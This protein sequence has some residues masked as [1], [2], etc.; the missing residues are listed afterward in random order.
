M[1]SSLSSTFYIIYKEIINQKDIEKIFEENYF[2]SFQV[3]L[4]DQ[5]GGMKFAF[6]KPLLQFYDDTFQIFVGN[7]NYGKNNR[8][9]I[10]FTSKKPADDD[11]IKKNFDVFF[12]YV[13]KI[14][15]N[16]ECLYTEF[17]LNGEL[18]SNLNMQKLDLNLKSMENPRYF[19]FNIF[20]GKL[21]GN[22]KENLFKQII[23]QPDIF[24]AKKYIL[25]CI[26]RVDY[27][28]S[29]KSLDRIFANAIDDLNVVILKFER[30]KN[31]E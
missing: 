19:G 30:N 13:K 31:D 3:P 29:I 7:Y 26:Y 11:G 8:G 25:N 21:D 28:N 5:T 9:V 24:D 22:L 2:K 1:K 16:K 18:D 17:D 6:T 23:I 12:E 15:I 20:D 27:K 4:I 14:K 10:S